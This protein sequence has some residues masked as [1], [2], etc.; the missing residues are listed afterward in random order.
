MDTRKYKLI[1][2]IVVI[3]T[4][5]LLVICGSTQ[6]SLNHVQNNKDLEKINHERVKNNNEFKLAEFLEQ[7]KSHEDT[8]LNNIAIYDSWGEVTIECNGDFTTF[9][10]LLNSLDDMNE[11]KEIKSL[12]IEEGLCTFKVIFNTK[13]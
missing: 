11:I 12:L 2:A 3:L 5:I 8:S 4:M 7:L 9:K 6:V 1:N 13:T 10:N